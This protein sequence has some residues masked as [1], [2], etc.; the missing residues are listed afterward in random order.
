MRLKTCTEKHIIVKASEC[1][2]TEATEETPNSHDILILKKTITN[3]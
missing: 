2:A 3:C 1:F